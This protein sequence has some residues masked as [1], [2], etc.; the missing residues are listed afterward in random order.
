MNEQQCQRRRPNW[1]SRRSDHDRGCYQ[2]EEP[3][4][5]GLAGSSI[6]LPEAVENE[7]CI[8][9]TS[10]HGLNS[11]LAGYLTQSFVSVLSEKTDGGTLSN[12]AGLKTASR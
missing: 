8:P 12:P 7:A 4:L 2:D 3:D 9:W 1:V 6:I 10:H 5:S 11:L